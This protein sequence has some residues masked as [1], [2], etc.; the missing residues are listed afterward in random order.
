LRTRGGDMLEIM[1]GL[2]F[3]GLALLVLWRLLRGA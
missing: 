1:A 2:A 3:T